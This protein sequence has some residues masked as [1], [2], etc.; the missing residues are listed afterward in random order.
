MYNEQSF[1]HDYGFG[2]RHYQYHKYTIY[3][4]DDQKVEY[5]IADE[6]LTKD[7]LEQLQP[8]CQCYV[9]SAEWYHVIAKYFS[10]RCCYRC[11]YSPFPDRYYIVK[12]RE[13]MST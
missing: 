4:S 7:E 8:Y 12:A 10:C 2:L 5:V 9:C 11:L 13:L 1:Q 3:L 6:Q